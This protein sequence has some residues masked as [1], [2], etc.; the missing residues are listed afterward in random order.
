V[1]WGDQKR[2][3]GP[4]RQGK[5]QHDGGWRAPV[6][7]AAGPRGLAGRLGVANHEDRPRIRSVVSSVVSRPGAKE[8]EEEEEEEGGRKRRRG[9][10]DDEEDKGRATLRRDGDDDGNG[11]DDDGHGRKR[12]HE[13]EEGDDFQRQSKSYVSQSPTLLLFMCTCTK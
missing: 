6:E 13:G 11:N 1:P 9:D 8:E 7:Q 5:W 3:D 10:E 12:R 2:A 4:P